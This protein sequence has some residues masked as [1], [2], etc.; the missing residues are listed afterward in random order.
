LNRRMA[1]I[2]ARQEHAAVVQGIIQACL[3]ALRQAGI[4][5]WDELYP[6]PELI[7]AD[8]RYGSLYLA[9]ESENCLGAVSLN[10]HQEAA[11]QQVNWHGSQPVL[12]VHRLCV[13]PAYQG[14]GIAG[15]LMDFAEDLA[16]RRGYASLRLD[17]YSGNPKAVRLYEGRDYRKAGQVYFPRR[18]LPFFCFEKILTEPKS[19]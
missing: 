1:I 10:E 12:V 8:I 7:E 2:Q 15:R 3:Q 13:A 14:K 16:R 19:E 11:Y 18:I 6:N 5:Q 17:A 4:F 9:Q